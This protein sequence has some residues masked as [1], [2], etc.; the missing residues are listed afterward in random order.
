MLNLP[1][2]LIR[3][4]FTILLTETPLEIFNFTKED[5]KNGEYDT[6]EEK[7]KLITFALKR[8]FEKT[9]MALFEN[10]DLINIFE[11]EN[12]M[13]NID[14]LDFVRDKSL[15]YLSN[16]ECLTFLNVKNNL[17]I[18][19]WLMKQSSPLFI[20]YEKFISDAIFD[21]DLKSLKW[22]RSQN[23][24][25]SWDPL[26]FYLCIFYENIEILKWIYSQNPPSF[27]LFDEN[28]YIIAI[29]KN[30]LE[31]LKWLRSQNP[32]CPWNKELILEISE[33]YPLLKDWIL[34]QKD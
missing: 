22:L 4:T 32:P 29:G 16:D 10:R 20:L 25:C 13:K 34:Q 33:K 19:E 2:D 23:P 1:T 12:F 30:N 31:I 21:N 8:N 28:C 3:H 27:C 11:T 14:L 9:K 7:E 15:I 24:P 18:L 17:K 6:Y 5:F 26:C